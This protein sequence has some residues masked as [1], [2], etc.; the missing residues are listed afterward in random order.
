[1]ESL[2][3]SQV[4]ADLSNLGAAVC[5]TTFYNTIGALRPSPAIVYKKLSFMNLVTNL[6]DRRSLQQE[7]AAAAAIVNAHIPIIQTQLIKDDSHAPSQQQ[8]RPSS[9]LRRAWSS[10]AGTQP[11]FDKMGRRLLISSPKSG[12]AASSIP[13]TPQP[14][15]VRCATI[16]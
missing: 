15:N 3:L 4:L 11:K 8:Q 9:G 2:Q 14:S 12:S 6:T 1:M 10:E 5:L 16:Y 7:P 13:G